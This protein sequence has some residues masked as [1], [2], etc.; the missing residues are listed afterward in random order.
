MIVYCRDHGGTLGVVRY[1]GDPVRESFESRTPRWRAHHAEQIG[2]TG[3]D[4]VFINLRDTTRSE[5]PAQGCPDCLKT[6][7]V[8]RAALLEAFEAGRPKIRL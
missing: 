4:N 3:H 5:V 7:T 6:R 2:L 1:R 8:K